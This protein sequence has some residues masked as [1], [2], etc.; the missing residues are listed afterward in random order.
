MIYSILPLNFTQCPITHTHVYNKGDKNIYYFV[1]E[2][3][4]M[5]EKRLAIRDGWSNTSM[6]SQKQIT[7]EYFDAKCITI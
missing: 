4:V 3:L 1:N 5:D 7:C 2:V 6:L